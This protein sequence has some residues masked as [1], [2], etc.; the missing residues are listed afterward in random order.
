MQSE[1]SGMSRKGVKQLRLYNNSGDQAFRSLLLVGA[2]SIALASAGQQALAAPLPS[3]CSVGGAGDLTL[4]HCDDASVVA[5]VRAGDTSLTVE[6]VEI[7]DGNINYNPH[8]DAEGPLGIDLTITNSSIVSSSYGGININ[9]FV[10][11][12]TIKV[13]LGDDVSITSTAGFGGVWTRN[14]QSGDI[15]ILTGA[16]VDATNADGVHGTSNGGSVSITNT[17]DVISQT[18]RG[19]Y[20]DGTGEANFPALVHINNS[21]AVS[22][23]EAGIRAIGYTAGIN[24]QN[25]GDVTST[26]KQAIIAW[27]PDADVA[28]TN[29]GKLTAAAGVGLEGATQNGD[30]TIV[31]DNTINALRGINAAA[32]YSATAPGAGDVSV[33]NSSRITATGGAGISAST[34]LGHIEIVNSGV[35]TGIDGIWVSGPSAILMNSG[36]IAATGDG[37][38][39]VVDSG[40]TTLFVEDGSV[41][42]GKLTIS[43]GSLGI[44]SSA[45]IDL[46]NQIAGGGTLVKQ[47]GN[48]LTLSGDSSAFAGSVSV[49]S[50]IL[51]IVSTIGSSSVHAGS[52][53]GAI[54]KVSGEGAIWN[55]TGSFL[56]GHDGTGEV[57]VSG[58]AGVETFHTQ[59]GSIDGALTVEGEGSHWLSRSHAEIGR[60]SGS[61]GVLSILDGGVFETSGGGLYAGAGADITISGEGSKMLIGTLHT[62]MPATWSA[63]DG[64]F[65]L[66]E[67]KTLVSEGGLLHTDGGYIGGAGETL[68]EM[69]VT[70]QGSAFVN[71]LSMYVGGNGNGHVGYGFLT[72]SDGAIST[73]YTAAAGVDPG[74]FGT[75]L[76]TGDGARLESLSREG[77]SGNMRVGYGGH[78]K[79]IVQNGATLKAANII[80]IATQDTSTGVLVIGAEE[81]EVAV[82]PG[83]VIAANGLFFGRGDA[84][85]VFNHT[86]SNLEFGN[87][88]FGD[89]GKIRHLAGVT[90]LTADSPDYFGAVEVSGG[91]LTVNGNLSGADV[92]VAHGAALGGSGSVGSLIVAQGGT[93][94]PGNSVGELTIAG[95][96]LFET[97]STYD[98]EIEGA[99]HDRILVQTGNV[100]VQDGA[101]LNAAFVPGVLLDNPYDVIAFAAGSSGELIIEG[102]GFVLPAEENPLLEGAVGYTPTGITVTYQGVSTPWATLMST[103]NQASAANAVQALGKDSALYYSA[104]FLKEEDLAGTF[105]SMSGEI[106]ASMKSALV[107][108]SYLL[109]SFIMGR[110]A[111]DQ[112]TGFWISGFGGRGEADGGVNASGVE[113]ES[114]GTFMGADTLFGRWRVGVLAGYGNL[115]VDVD[116]R[117]SAG[118]SESYHLGIHTSG[119]AGVFAVRAALTQS[120]H[121]VTTSRSGVLPVVQGL[122]ASYDATTT[123]LVGEVG[124]SFAVGGSKIEPFAGLS[125]MY[126][127]T[128]AYA[129]TGGV[130]AL[131]SAS[132]T[133]EVTYGTLGARG[134]VALGAAPDGTSFRGLLAWR[135]AFGGDMPEAVHGFGTASGGFTV[136]GP[137]LGEDVLVAE[138][139]L[140]V[141]VASNVKINA[142]Y[143]GQYDSQLTDHG[144]FAGLRISF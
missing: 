96:V 44:S 130:A 104:M 7:S 29:S 64:W 131:V 60:T 31:N 70:G 111:T 78:G 133:T 14:N 98:T 59:I 107:E 119:N 37:S 123:Q 45:D 21:G 90:D 23:Y 2:A 19:I 61:A 69:I 46:D 5:V 77:Y 143:K 114:I 124:R 36:T 83:A 118:E 113:R 71:D 141:V 26:T 57:I 41:L 72:I 4:H 126:L 28:I 68:A 30:I 84:T 12:T 94:S 24:V 93:L 112:E 1:P 95:D 138:M 81:G 74:S 102:A 58:G 128:D 115:D 63:A 40:E 101:F 27:S 129:E 73:A 25:S 120:W 49:D 32:G 56:I 20:A 106:H 52:E 16:T 85:L 54:L 80:D 55:N 116:A 117:A 34:P 99:L 89:G 79:V 100:T 82:L 105:D 97:G 91:L 18:N 38:A 3:Y 9:S 109:R 6:G 86:G 137:K 33:T 144:V 43:N 47:G 67:G 42:T 88:M 51:S 134:S 13:T 136:T 142:G 122:T 50:G 108:E 35:V 75:I 139:G 8:P 48:T 65:S 132:R 22:A 127:K 140:D 135:H 11:D 92:E 87:V 66:D 76:L 53:A 62:D 125:H 121:D 10:E 17:G 103:P 15:T 39:I 110:A